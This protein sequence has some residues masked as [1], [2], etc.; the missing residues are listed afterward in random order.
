VATWDEFCH[1]FGWNDR[2]QALLSGLKKALLVLKTA[3]CKKVYIDG[4]FVTG[5]DVPG[6]FDGCWD[7]A[8]VSPALLDTT[9]LDFGGKR[10][11]QKAKYSGELFPFSA[12]PGVTGSTWLDF[13]QTDKATGNPKGVVVLDIGSEDL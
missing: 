12:N 3:G 7:A 13:F 4:S 9:L 11:A 2:R 10:E 5:K 8:G 1:R 6:D